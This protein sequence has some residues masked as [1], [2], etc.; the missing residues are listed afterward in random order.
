MKKYYKVVAKCGHV[1]RLNY[2]HK[3]FAVCANTASDAAQRV[4]DFPRVKKQL[5]TCITSCDEIEYD[6]YIAIKKANSEDGY[7]KSHTHREQMLYNPNIRDE[8]ISFE[9][10][11]LEKSK[12]SDKRKLIEAIEL[13]DLFRYITHQGLVHKSVFKV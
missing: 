10:K 8:V 2:I 5:K 3:T 4:K 7:F 12:V 6:E 11:M 9:P 13:N 1:K